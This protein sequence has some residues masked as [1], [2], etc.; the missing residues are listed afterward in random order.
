M[1]KE[2]KK[3]SERLGRLPEMGIY[4][5]SELKLL[6]QGHWRKR[7]ENGCLELNV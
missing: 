7:F 1:K 3:K 6:R 5:H 4:I 2:K